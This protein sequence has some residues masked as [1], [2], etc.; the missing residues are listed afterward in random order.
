MTEA[1]L[2]ALRAQGLTDD[3]AYDVAEVAAIYTFTDRMAMAAHM[4]P[5][6]EYHALAR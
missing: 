1:D 4:L 3:E 6:A 5:N 2:R